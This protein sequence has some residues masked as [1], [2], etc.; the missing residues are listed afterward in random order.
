MLYLGDYARIGY[1]SVTPV[2]SPALLQQ[3]TVSLVG[4]VPVFL[5]EDGVMPSSN[6]G[7]D[8]TSIGII[9][10]NDTT[11][12]LIAIALSQCS[13]QSVIDSIN[14]P[15]NFGTG[16]QIM[17]VVSKEPLYLEA[18]MLIVQEAGVSISQTILPI[19]PYT[20]TSVRYTASLGVVSF[21][22]QADNLIATY[23]SED[24]TT[25]FN[26]T[27][28][29]IPVSISVPITDLSVPFE[30][31]GLSAIS[32]APPAQ[33]A[34]LAGIVKA[35]TAGTVGS[36]SFEVGDYLMF[37]SGVA[38]CIVIPKDT[39][40]AN[41]ISVEVLPGGIIDTA[42][43][44][45]I[46]S[47]LSPLQQFLVDPIISGVTSTNTP[48]DFPS[49]TKYIVPLGDFTG[50]TLPN[51]YKTILKTVDGGPYEAFEIL[52]YALVRYEG[53]QYI[54]NPSQ[55]GTYFVDQEL[56]FQ[57]A[58][59]K[60]Q[61]D[62]YK[63]SIGTNYLEF[64]I[65]DNS[66]MVI[67][68][69]DNITYT[70]QATNFIGREPTKAFGK[71]VIVAQNNIGVMFNNTNS[72]D[73]ET[74]S[75]VTGEV[76]VVDWIYFNGT[77]LIQEISRPYVDG[78]IYETQTLNNVLLASPEV[79]ILGNTRFVLLTG[80]ATTLSI[81]RIGNGMTNDLYIT[82]NYNIPSLSIYDATSNSTVGPYTL[83]AGGFLQF[84]VTNTKQLVRV[85]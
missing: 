19:D 25:A 37:Y 61:L 74:I 26:L 6:L 13:S 67:T 70:I 10:T 58:L 39:K 60:P 45:A 79:N 44:T 27:L 66:F 50:L 1:S 49:G 51:L 47:V 54:F 76:V 80:D 48:E 77:F 40:I 14:T 35:T 38:E 65:I 46:N 78:V 7:I 55:Y 82:S 34:N 57:Y 73:I 62:G 5:P 9:G 4:Q 33:A 84:K 29:V 68:L 28:V 52:D 41:T 56:P 36:S 8:N 21:Y 2:T 32:V 72:Q 17:L 53:V 43:F 30:V 69:S 81:N 3:G 42:I 31:T 23:T 63:E 83:A 16:I 24:T 64:S 71:L 12:G 11:G 18:A 15:G 59:N 75:M 20:I 85:G 22:D